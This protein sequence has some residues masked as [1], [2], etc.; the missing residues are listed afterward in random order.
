MREHGDIR[1]VSRLP[2]SEADVNQASDN[3][4]PTGLWAAAVDGHME[5]VHYLLEHGAKLNA[6][7]EERGTPLY[8]AASRCNPKIAL[9]L[10]Q[11]GAAVNLRGN[12]H[13][14]PLNLRDIIDI[15]QI[16]LE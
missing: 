3:G 11:H 15:P 1:K 9:E 2:K 14:R 13:I 10:L 5:I 7:N 12:W 16:L 4:C 6:Q 8:T